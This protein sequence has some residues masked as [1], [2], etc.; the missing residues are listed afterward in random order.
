MNNHG[1]RNKTAPAP[2]SKQ[3]EWKKA[4]PQE[5]SMLRKIYPDTDQDGVPDRY[6]CEPEN[7]KKQDFA[8]TRT[9]IPMADLSYMYGYKKTH[10]E[11]TPN[12]FLR[13]T[14]SQGTSRIRK[15]PLSEYESAVIQPVKVERLKKRIASPY[16]EV[17][18]PLLELE[19]GKV[20]EH[21]G[22]HRA[23]AAREL[24]YKKIPVVI[25]ETGKKKIL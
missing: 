25:V 4:Y 1:F 22:R 16:V 7:P 21:E 2:L 6:D 13:H 11:M 10:T 14:Q 12:E 19:K 3:T 24:G 20:V 17:D 18:V 5:R 23:V 9:G 15:W 8:K